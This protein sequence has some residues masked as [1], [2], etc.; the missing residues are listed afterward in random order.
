MMDMQAA[1]EQMWR[2]KT[3]EIIDAAK[4]EILAALPVFRGGKMSTGAVPAHAST[5]QNGGADEISVAGLSGVLA[6]PQTPAAHNQTA[7]TIT[8]FETAHDALDHAGLTGVPSIAGLLDETAH[9]LL[10]HTGLTG[11]G[12]SVTV[13]EQDGSPSVSGVSVIEFATGTVVADQTGGVVRVTP[14]GGSLTVKEIDSAPSVASVTEIRVT[15]GTLTDV[16]GG[17]VQLDFGSAA[18]DGA[19][20]HDNVA[21]EIHAVTE[22]TTPV[23]DD[24]LIIEDSADSYNKKRLKIANLPGGTGGA[25]YQTLTDGATINW[26]LSAGSGVVT[27]GGDRTLANPTNIQAGAHYHLVAIQDA[28]GVRK[29]SYGNAY[30]FASGYGPNLTS[31]AGA[32]D[33]LDFV[34]SADKLYCVGVRKALS[35]WTYNN[36]EYSTVDITPGQTYNQSEYYGGR[37]GARAFDDAWGSDEQG[38]IT[39]GTVLNAWLSVDFGSGK[40]IGKVTFRNGAPQVANRGLKDCEL[41]G[42]N[43]NTN[44]TKVAATSAESGAS[45]QNTDEFRLG[46]IVPATLQTVY[47]ATNTASYRYYRVFA[48]NGWGDASYIGL[49]EVEMMEIL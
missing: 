1:L 10:D 30:Y 15:N 43:D 3:R 2:R 4:A 26:D 39:N 22:K 35:T 24:E 16:G 41:E 46:N 9:D 13:R 36:P 12:G 37:N 11:V 48:T 6:D 23:D 34:A 8:D 47:F 7:S 45:V 40:N 25:A 20:I 42:S 19:A 49:S 28:T 14:A 44:W 33:V 32:V 31:T 21:S 27:L 18:T 17:V 29:L 5:H 38:W